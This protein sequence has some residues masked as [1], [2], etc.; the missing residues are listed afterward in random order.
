MLRVVQVVVCLGLISSGV[1]C[2]QSEGGAV[3]LSWL[4]RTPDGR[5][6]SD[7][8]CADPAISHIR[9]ELV[10]LSPD[11]IKDSRPCS[12]RGTCTFACDRGT[13]VTPLD[14]PPGNYA[15][16]IMPLGADGK[17]LRPLGSIGVPPAI[18]RDVIFGQVTGLGA[19]QVV[20]PCA[21]RCASTAASACSN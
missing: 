14:I 15:I 4:V 8:G 1:G 12:E 2:T 3:E 5:T 11:D 20:A 21:S 7:C 13:G 6:V 16:E 18:V 9:V 17:D 10:G 19:L